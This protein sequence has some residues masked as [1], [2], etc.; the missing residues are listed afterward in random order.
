MLR[1]KVRVRDV[2]QEW[3]VWAAWGEPSQVEQRSWNWAA[4]GAV[5]PVWR[6]SPTS[7]WGTEHGI[8]LDRRAP[9][10]GRRLLV[11]KGDRRPWLLLDTPFLPLTN[12]CCTAQEASTHDV[13]A[14]DAYLLHR[15]MHGVPEGGADIQPLH[16][17]PIESNLDVMGGRA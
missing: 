9:G 13:L 8:I 2:T 12:R 6:D 15:I 10:V 1:S 17:F 11:H 16:A 4:S 14:A 5:E 7:P 3:D